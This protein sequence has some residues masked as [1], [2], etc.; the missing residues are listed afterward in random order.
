MPKNSGIRMTRILALWLG[1]VLLCVHLAVGAVPPD[2]I[3]LT[4]AE[5]SWLE[6]HPKIRVGIMN[7]WPP[8][9]YV[10]EDGEPRG[11]GTRFIKALNGRLGDRL[12]IV[13]GPWDEVYDAV[14]DKRLDALMDIT[15]RP[16]RA[17]FLL[18][19]QPYIDVPHLIFT[20]KY[21]SFKGS[22]QE[23]AGKK[24]AVEREFFLAKLLREKHPQITTREFDNTR[25]ALRALARGEVDAYVGNRAVAMHI[26][27]KE[28]ISN[29]VPAGKIT[30]SSS[31]NAIGVRKDWPVLRD[32]LQKALDAIPAEER[33]RIIN[34]PDVLAQKEIQA[35]Q[36][37]KQL[38][39]GEKAWLNEHK[40]FH[41]A[42]MDGW[43]PFNYV[44]K[45]GV[46]AGIGIDYLNALNKRL[47]NVL[48][49]VPGEWKRIYE[50]V[51]EKRL[52]AIMD[53]TPKP[54]REPFFHFTTPYLEVPHV[55]V[56]RKDSVFLESELSLEGKTL[57]LEQGFGNV[58]HFHKYYPD[59]KLKLFANT[60][61]ALDAV[62]RGDADAYAGN[63]VVAL[64]LMDKHFITN[65]RVHGSLT[66]PASALTLG[67]RKDWPQFRDILQ[68]ALD[69]ISQEEHRAIIN[70][71]IHMRETEG[72]Q[73]NELRLTAEELKWLSEHR[74]IPIGVDGNWPP[75]DFIDK[76]GEHAGI[77]AD[78]L[79]LLG[80][81]LGVKFVAEKSPKF[82]DMLQKVMEGELKVG[83]TI[84]YNE[85]RAKKLYFSK[86][87]YQVHRVIIARDDSEW[88]GRIEDLY[89][90]RVAIED[91]FITMALLREKH[92]QI[93]L[94]PVASSLEA[95][96]M[97]SEGGADAY[98][99]NQAVVGW[100]LKRNQLNNLRVAGNPGLGSGPQS[101]SVSRAAPDWQP[102]ISIIDK[103]LANLTEEERR[104]LEQRW[105]GK[106]DV[107]GIF[108]R[109]ILTNEEHHWLREHKS[110]RLGVDAD[111]APVEFIDADGEYEGISSEYM[112][113]FAAQLGINWV[114]PR[115]ISWAEVQARLKNKSL[116]VAPMISRTPE[117]EDYLIFT[118]PYLDF[119]YVIFNRR[120]TTQLR[121]LDDL[122]GKKVAAIEGYSIV[123]KLRKDYPLIE[124]TFYQ[125]V[126]E[127]LQAVSVGEVDAFVGSLAVGGYLIGQEGLT[128]L[129]VAAPTSYSRKYGIGVRKDW[130][131]LVGILNKAIDTLDDELKNDIFRRWSTVKYEQH[132]DYSLVWKILGV[133]LLVLVVGSIWIMQIRR[134]R[135]IIQQGRERL[136]LT[137]KSA[138]L[139]AWEARVSPEG[140]PELLSLD[141]TF[142]LHHGMSEA[143]EQIS[144]E[145]LYSYINQENIPTIREGI[146]HFLLSQGKED[147]SFE[148]RVRGQDR[149]LYSKGHTLEWDE[150]G[151]PKYVVGITQD[152]TERH[153]ANEA[154]QQANRFKGEFLANMSHE[155][156]TPMN[157]II[158]LGHLLGK[159]SLVTKQSDYVHKIQVSAKSLLSIIDDIL[160]FS[161]I[162]AGRLTIESIPFSFDGIF[163]NLSI[164]ANTRIGDSHIEFLYDVDSDLPPKLE[165]D[166]Y[167]IGQILTNL[168]SNAVKFTQSGNIVVRIKVLKREPKKIW[169]RFEVEDTGIGIDPD[170]LELL[171]QPFT[172]ADG[173]T[174]RNYGGTGLGLSICQKL[175][176][177]MHG[178]IGAESEP[179][180]GSLFYFELPLTYSETKTYP[181]LHHV[182]RNLRVLLVDDNP[183]AQAVLKDML[184]SMTFE[185]TVAGSGAEALDRLKEP[186]SEFDLVLLDWQMPNIDGFET[187]R[188]IDKLFGDERPVVIMMTAYGREIMEQGLDNKQIDGLLVKPLTPSILFDAIVSAY[189]SKTATEPLPVTTEE[190]PS[191]LQQL[192]GTILLVED[193][194]INRQVGKELLEQMGLVV[195]C[196]ENGE[197]AVEYFTQQRPDL[198]L[199]DIQMPVMDGYEATRCIRELPGMDDLPIFAMT[200]NALVGDADKS[201]QAGMNGHIAKPI[202]PDELYHILGEYLESSL[203]EQ[204]LSSADKEE[205]TGWTPPESNPPDIDLHH[206]IKQVGGKPE[207][208]LKLLGDFL[209]NHGNSVSELEQMMK[210]SRL[211]D[212]R[213]TAHTLKGVAGNIGAHGLQK[214][215]SALEMCFSNGEFP[216][217]ELFGGFS[218]VCES[219]FTTIRNII[220]ASKKFEP[221]S[222]S[223]DIGVDD[224]MKELHT[225]VAELQNGEATSVNLYEELKP[226]LK[227]QLGSV[228]FAE[229]D[230]LVSGY[231]LEEAA[232]LLQKTLAG[233]EQFGNRDDAKPN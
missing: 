68:R 78:Y 81:R 94:I 164:L 6:N 24:V 141:E 111:W 32:I 42:V 152:I 204:T 100:L 104:R 37:S 126:K 224:I 205:K 116:D 62:S 18:F 45:D 212:A 90:R 168:V 147:L 97:V 211:V 35:K 87:F 61:L 225:F 118:K 29:V 110:I 66:K 232:A 178:S 158:G 20:R 185:V 9:D 136:E 80:N 39:A 2:S 114:K 11:I 133:A 228:Q 210:E 135:R 113:I 28:L 215:A 233:Q 38:T 23:L 69:D 157:A 192:Q 193:N 96:Q 144:L 56:A 85:E 221:I 142:C 19:T 10:D 120:G 43:P 25:N 196:A 222:G 86:P 89:G 27:D 213:R 220:P 132:I 231:E 169:L 71:W 139:G 31:V 58:R 22:L 99:G 107:K 124:L 48:K 159:T 171:F 198:V 183:T 79:N 51:K 1:L 112:R 190:L 21:E 162:E 74:E 229:L 101:F 172:Q 5:Q 98:V 179:G 214:I 218:R 73:Q 53:I 186:D 226:V 57:A 146:K 125:N 44:D 145:D 199:M 76:E 75:I 17:E 197:Q 187:I 194:E 46:S 50:D 47:G 103:A 49:P 33:T 209:K 182:L 184:E 134:S 173:S 84:S 121:G 175:C 131:E 150:S 72:A 122:A 70:R 60:V 12:E 106:D 26:I 163:E 7:A 77:T 177:L 59:V 13:P 151:R 83:A 65:L 208:Y 14:R 128:N 140:I 174:T 195:D 219:L 91:G 170:R 156:R 64:Y 166:P 137:L 109:V 143:T 41:I 88:I 63:R 36:F 191:P 16:D 54:E 30:E 148:Y 108:P 92:P 117:R 119:P 138:Q 155:I 15:P 149:W 181:T 203:P 127:A 115:K 223:R 160:D 176:T 165:G 130:P 161:K 40:P 188:R 34:P 4:E 154:L 217:E 82:R 189:D 200:A 230:R 105:L 207:F 202:D 129:Q 180:K 201:I 206:G 55:I 102:L 216:S 52:D 153:K 123:K 3:G 93:D 227:Q 95:L 67:V 8:M 167:R